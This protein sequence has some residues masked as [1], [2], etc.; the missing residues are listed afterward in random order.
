MVFNA[1][2]TIGS[3]FAKADLKS[4]ENKFKEMEFKLFQDNCP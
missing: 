1:G 4:E 2:R 3:V